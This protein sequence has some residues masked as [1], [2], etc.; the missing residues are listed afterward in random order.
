MSRRRLR[1]PLAQLCD[2][3]NNAVQG[4]ADKPLLIASANSVASAT[5]QLLSAATVRMDASSQ[6][7]Q[8]LRAAGAAVTKATK[9][10][11][12]AA[13]ANMAL[14]DPNKVLEDFASLSVVG[15][16]RLELEQKARL[17]RLRLEYEKAQQEYL[18]TQGLK[19]KN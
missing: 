10:L 15:Q 5:A 4:N 14:D 6:S 16:R 13:E 9:Q 3:A 18:R 8:R 11:V 12:E 17:E 7:S 2:N 1:S 19:Y